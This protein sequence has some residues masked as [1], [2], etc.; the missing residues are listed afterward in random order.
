MH[1]PICPAV[2]TATALEAASSITTYTKGTLF[3]PDDR[4]AAFE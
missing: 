1:I 3:K 4:S 2:A